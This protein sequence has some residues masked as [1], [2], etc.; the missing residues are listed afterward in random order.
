MDYPLIFIA[1]Q[2]QLFAESL[3]RI[4]QKNDY[5][6]LRKSLPELNIFEHPFSHE[7]SLL[8]IEANWPFPKLEC[9]LEKFKSSNGHEFKNI[10]VS[11][12]I[13]KNIFRLATRHQIHGIIL[14]QSSMDEFLFGVKQVLEGKTFYSSMAT[15]MFLRNNLDSR[16][17]KISNR[18]KQILSLLAKMYSTEEIANKL[19]I[20]KS[21]VKTHRRNLM[22]R[23]NERN[24]L[25]LLRLA[26]RENLLSDNSDFC[27]CCYK[28]FV[29]A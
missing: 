28:K 8:I 13:T 11:N 17:L 22:R 9:I 3:E 10:L 25:G 23:F 7:I 27:E 18:E 20:S 26:C 5:T 15:N 29:G 19:S 21:T 14:E 2:N 4:L 1:Y 16:N 24:L 12:L 6:V